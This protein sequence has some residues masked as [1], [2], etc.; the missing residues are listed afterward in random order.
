M[1]ATGP[2][3]DGDDFSRRLAALIGEPEEVSIPVDGV[4]VPFTVWREA[5]HC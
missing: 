4:P 3:A 1:N 5:H 2:P